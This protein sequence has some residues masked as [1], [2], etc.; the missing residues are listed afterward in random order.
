MCVKACVYNEA[1]CVALSDVTGEDLALDVCLV[2]QSVL[3]D[4]VE[5]RPVRDVQVDLPAC[6]PTHR[7]AHM[8]RHLFISSAKAGTNS[9]LAVAVPWAG[10]HLVTQSSPRGEGRKLQL[11][12]TA[13]RVPAVTQ[14]IL[15]WTNIVRVPT[16]SKTWADRSPSSTAM[17]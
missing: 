6:T 17:P 12:R 16:V 5:T 11:S 8:R 3:V 13:C 1:T 4:H 10:S 9:T 7:V 2:A 15:L 14:A